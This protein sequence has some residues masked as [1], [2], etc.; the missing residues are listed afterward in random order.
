MFL[1]DTKI[2]SIKP[3]GKKQSFSDGAGVALIITA[4]GSKIWHF[5]YDRPNNFK[6]IQNNISLGSYPIV[7]LKEARIKRDEFK[8]LLYQGVDPAI[9]RKQDKVNR[10]TVQ[11]QTVRFV[12]TEWFECFKTRVSNDHAKRIWQR[13]ERNVFPQIGE[14]PIDSI[15][16]EKIM[17]AIK[18]IVSRGSHD[19]AERTL[20]VCQEIF[21]YATVHGLM[22]KNPLEQIKT[23]DV[24]PSRVVENQKRVNVSDFPKLIQEIN[25]YSGNQLYKLALKLMVL[26]FVRHDELR[27]AEWS[28]F[29]FDK[30]IWTIPAH[31]MKMKSP[32][33]VPL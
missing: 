5:R 22:S 27:F 24:I 18:K 31:K 1:N 11:Q 17:R 25:N 12:T 23:R 8:T 4:K 30:N 10:I 7:S 33:K 13:L 15:T 28:E 9:V 2:K 19:V 14:D 16:T 32:H 21:R 26:V 3:N 6:R 20:K 29:D